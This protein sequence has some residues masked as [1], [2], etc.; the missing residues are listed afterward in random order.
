MNAGAIKDLYYDK[1]PWSLV[2]RVI[3]ENFLKIAEAFL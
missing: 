3:L 2:L 1:G